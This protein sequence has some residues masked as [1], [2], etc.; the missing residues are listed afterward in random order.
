LNKQGMGSISRAV[1][2]WRVVPAV[3]AL[4]VLPACG[5]STT[6]PSGPQRTVIGTQNGVMQPLT[7]G[8]HPV[9]ANAS[10]TFDVTLDWGNAG[11]DFDIIVTSNACVTTSMTDLLTGA[12]N[13]GHITS[14][15]SATVKP[16]RVTWGGTANVT[17]R[18]W[19]ANFGGSADSYT[20][21]AGITN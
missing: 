16:E 21:T 5:K 12:A 14:A 17:Y 19:V 4:A 15:T 13:C 8:A 10:G 11:N 3:L 2:I 20:V 7:A 1:V 18:V 9:V 6:G